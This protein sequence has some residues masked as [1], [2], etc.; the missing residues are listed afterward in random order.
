MGG[1]AE[2]LYI[3]RDRMPRPVAVE[4]EPRPLCIYELWNPPEAPWNKRGRGYTYYV[5]VY[6]ATLD[7]AVQP[8][9]R[10]VDALLW[11]T[12]E[13]VRRTAQGALTVQ[14]LLD[15]GAAMEAREAIP[16]HWQVG[17]QGT[18]HALAILWGAGPQPG[19]S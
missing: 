19:N 13:Q 10:D 2:T 18:A 3:G 9:P 7:H 14:A 8:H 15:D 1:A 12:P 17:P 5:V 16:G 6:Q 11:L 4:D